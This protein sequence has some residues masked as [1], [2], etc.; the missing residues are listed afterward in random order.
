[1]ASRERERPE[2]E[3][4]EH[5]LTPPRRIGRDR[6]GRSQ[7][8][9]RGGGCTRSAGTDRPARGLGPRPERHAPLASA[10][11][12]NT[13]GRSSGLRL[14]SVRLAFPR[15]SAVAVER[16]WPNTAAALRRIL[17]GFPLRPAPATR[18]RE[19][20]VRSIP[21]AKDMV[22]ATETTRLPAACP[23][24][25]RG[26]FRCRRGTRPARRTSEPTLPS[27]TPPRPASTPTSP[28]RSTSRI[29]GHP[30]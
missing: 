1:M 19:P 5:G 2:L 15:L 4:T 30:G 13:T 24:P 6:F 27:P 23:A 28:A 11:A 14:V 26:D 10:S 20:V 21:Y 8:S 17:T 22:A 18:T 12:A 9:E 29:R 7:G 16:T 25:S 3:T